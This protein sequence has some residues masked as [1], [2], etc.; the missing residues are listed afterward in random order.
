MKAS[1]LTGVQSTDFHTGRA[2]PLPT[3][4]PDWLECRLRRTEIYFIGAPR[5]EDKGSTTMVQILGK[6]KQVMRQ[7]IIEV[8]STDHVPAPGESI[9]HSSEHFPEPIRVE[10]AQIG[11]TSM[12][13]KR[14]EE[15]Q[16]DPT[17][18]EVRMDIVSTEPETQK[19]SVVKERRT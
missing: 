15:K 7:F 16:V 10:Q 4:L 9:V 5:V 3:G 17:P 11:N 13:T 2:F 8:S 14:E 6:N 1:H 12:G 18:P 19:T